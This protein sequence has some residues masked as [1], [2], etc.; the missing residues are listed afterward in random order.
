MRSEDERELK[1]ILD[2]AFQAFEAGEDDLA[3]RLCREALSLDPD[4]GTAHSL[5]GLL[6]EREGRTAEATGEFAKVLT[7]NPQSEAER[8]TLRRLRGD[9]RLPVYAEE[10]DRRNTTIIAV[11]AVAALLVFAAIFFIGS[12]VMRS[13][14]R[15]AD[16]VQVASADIE[17]DL[18][19]AREAFDAGRYQT[20]MEAAARVLRA[21][22]AHAVAREIYER[23]R[24]FLEGTRQPA[25]PAPT[26][27][28]PPQPVQSQPVFPGPNAPATAVV[29]RAP[30]GASAPATTVAPAPVAPAPVGQ[31]TGG[32]PRVTAPSATPTLAARQPARPAIGYDP[33]ATERRRMRYQRPRPVTGRY[34]SS[35]DELRAPDT[36]R[37]ESVGPRSVGSTE[38][39]EELPKDE[40]YI[41]IEVK[42]RDGEAPATAKPEV[43]PD[44]DGEAGDAKAAKNATD[45]TSP[46]VQQW[47]REQQKRLE[48][49]Q[50]QKAAESRRLER[51]QGQ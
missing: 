2:E 29:P 35:Y 40:P 45:P 42:R 51:E 39:A 38:A 3:R 46:V 19:L 48:A 31:A 30:A 14:G 5:M 10:E 41:K 6:Y 44:L 21:D 49:R 37:P 47:Q 12:V 13:V 8:R 22:P 25:A 17:G 26:G 20:A 1:R 4:S 43:K 15:H 16:E 11:A 7:L 33:T 32:F 34:P 23:S 18:A 27:P 9:A 24:A 28:P 50:R 36:V